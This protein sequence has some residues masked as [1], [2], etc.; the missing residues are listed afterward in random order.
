MSPTGNPRHQK[1]LS[2]ILTI[3]H[4]RNLVAGSRFHY[5]LLVT[6]DS[7]ASVVIPKMLDWNEIDDGHATQNFWRANLLMPHFQIA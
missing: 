3:T 4:P 2:G 7:N 5:Q 6:N 1:I